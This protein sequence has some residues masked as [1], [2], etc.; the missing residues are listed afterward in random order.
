MTSV[1]TAFFSIA[2]GLSQADAHNRLLVDQCSDEFLCPMFQSIYNVPVHLTELEGKSQH[3]FAVAC[4]LHPLGLVAKN[5]RDT[6]AIN[7][8]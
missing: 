7:G 4:E 1:E 6:I 3:I 8:E 5:D 2:N